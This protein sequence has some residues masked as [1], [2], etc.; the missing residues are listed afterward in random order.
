ML[1]RVFLYPSTYPFVE[2]VIGFFKLVK[3]KDFLEQ[4]PPFELVA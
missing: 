3:E 2:V 1:G 4:N